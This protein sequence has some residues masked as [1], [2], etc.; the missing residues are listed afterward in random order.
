M[1]ISILTVFQVKKVFKELPGKIH[2]LT[3]IRMIDIHKT[4]VYRKQD[5]VGFYSVIVKHTTCLC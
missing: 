4:V 5:A 1:L 2:L 3:I